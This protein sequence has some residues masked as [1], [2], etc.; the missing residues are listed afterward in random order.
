[1]ERSSVRYT[2]ADCAAPCCARA[3][4]GQAA[5]P[6]NAAINSRRPI[7]AGIRSIAQCGSARAAGESATRCRDL[8]QSAIQQPTKGDRLSH[9]DQRRRRA[10]RETTMDRDRRAFLKTPSLAAAAAAAGLP[11]ATE[12]V[13]QARSASVEMKELPKGLVLATL[14][15]PD[16]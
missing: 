5:A 9:A 10:T 8:R 11:A 16:S 13:A 2:Q 6:P 1:Y 15:R 3:A 4:S 12:A 14:R 7:V